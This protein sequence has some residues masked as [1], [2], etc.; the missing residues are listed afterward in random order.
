M[1]YCTNI[2][3][4]KSGGEVDRRVKYNIEDTLYMNFIIKYALNR[5][6]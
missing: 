3:I 1:S 2:E 4:I 6:Q 5:Y